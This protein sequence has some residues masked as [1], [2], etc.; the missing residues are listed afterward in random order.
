MM[1]SYVSI[2][3]MTLEIVDRF[4]GTEEDLRYRSPKLEHIIVPSQF[5]YRFII[6][7]RDTET[8]IITFTEDIDAYNTEQLAQ[9]D[10]QWSTL[11]SERNSKLKACDWIVCVPDAPFTIEAK[12]KWTEYRQSLRDLPANTTDPQNP[13]WPEAPAS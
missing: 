4:K 11:R 5:D 10:Y 2:D 9:Y 6:P 13:I 1:T 8:G 7:H 3:P 12:Q